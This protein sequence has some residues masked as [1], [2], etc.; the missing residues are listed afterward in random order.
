MSS[1]NA[2]EGGP[3]RA[4]FNPGGDGEQEI[5]SRAFLTENVGVSLSPVYSRFF[6]LKYLHRETSQN[7]V[8]SFVRARLDSA[9]LEVPPTLLLEA[10]FCVE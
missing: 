1:F 5:A 2:T 6:F 9:A 4:V 10:V 3:A 7:S 8:R